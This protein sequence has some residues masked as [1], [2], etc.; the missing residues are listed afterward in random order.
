MIAEEPMVPP[1]TPSF[2]AATRS[3]EP[4]L[5]PGE[6]R[7]RPRDVCSATDGGKVST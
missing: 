5:P 6:A 4:G 3:R 1:R 7:L 2:A